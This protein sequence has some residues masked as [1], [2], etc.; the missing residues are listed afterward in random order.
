MA[1]W[2]A[3]RAQVTNERTDPRYLEYWDRVIDGLRKAGLPET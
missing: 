2:R 1:A 3:Y